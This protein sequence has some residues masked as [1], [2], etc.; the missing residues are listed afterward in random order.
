MGDEKRRWTADEL[1]EHWS[2]HADELALVS[3]ARTPSNQLGFALLLKWFQLRDSFP[4][5]SKMSPSV[6][7]FLARQLEVDPELF[8]AIC[9]RAA[10]WNDTAP[11]FASI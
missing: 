11:K 5:A 9:G 7:E 2:L 4:G 3:S 10:R 8:R 6:V 1:L